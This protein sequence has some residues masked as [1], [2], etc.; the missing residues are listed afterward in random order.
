MSTILIVGASGKICRYVAK[1]LALRNH[2]LILQCRSRCEELR[3]FLKANKDVSSRIK[4][5]VKHDFISEGVE[6]FIG[7][8]RSLI[9]SPPDVVIVCVG[10][11]DDS[12]FKDSRDDLVLKILVTNLMTH[13]RITELI[14]SWINE[15]GDGKSLIILLTDLTPVKG[16]DVYCGLKPSLSY[17]A[18][19]AGVHALIRSAPKRLPPSLRIVGVSLGW[20]EGKHLSRDLIE[21]IN[22]SVPAGRPVGIDD[23]VKLINELISGLPESL[24]GSVIELSNGL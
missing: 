8:V 13:I 15:V 2:E 24:N 11:Y 18:C 1:E 19:S 7:K 23:V 6:G 10:V 12:S 14:A 5:I 21:C 3:G 4:A 17:I 9:T 16:P 20:V 22:A